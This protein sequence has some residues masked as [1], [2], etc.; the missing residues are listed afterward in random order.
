MPFGKN[1]KHP[2]KWEAA[3]LHEVMKEREYTFRCSVVYRTFNMA[4]DYFGEAGCFHSD[5]SKALIIT[6]T[7]NRFI[8]AP[9]CRRADWK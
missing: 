4:I 6:E 8:E 1:F 3:F 5:L 9:D 2:K 7:R